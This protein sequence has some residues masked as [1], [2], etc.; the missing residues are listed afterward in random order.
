MKKRSLIFVLITLCLALL[1]VAAFAAD[2]QLTRAELAEMVYN[3]FLP[4]ASGVLPEFSDIAGC[5]SEQQQAIRVMAANGVISGSKEGV[6]DPYGVANRGMAA[7]II[8][9]MYGNAPADA[10]TI[11]ND[12]AGTPFAPAIDYLA[13][14]GILLATDAIDGGF[15]PFEPASVVDVSTW[16]SR[17]NTGNE[18]NG[19]ND[20]EVGVADDENAGNNETPEDENI[21]DEKI[22]DGNAADADDTNTDAPVT[23]SRVYIASDWAQW[24]V[25]YADKLGLMPESFYDKDL[26]QN[27]TRAEFAAVAVKVYEA[28]AGTPALPAVVHPFTDTNDIEVLKAYNVGITNG[29]GDGT[30]YEPDSILN[31]EQL[32]TM[33][34]RVFKRVTIPGWTLATDAQFELPYEM[35]ALFADDADISGWARDS[36]YFMAANNIVGGVGENRYAPKNTTT[37]EE[38]I[39]YANATREQA[40]LIA[41]RMVENLGK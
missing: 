13:A 18:N 10:Q 5:T 33:L 27:I 25:A 7:I 19:D 26:T 1:P 28:L 12:A 6:F 4:E 17:I 11:F 14:N 41:V 24:E 30:V 20:T 21:D 32:A 15:K 3:K 8:W 37:E 40:L 36:V 39:G 29:T 38:A 16:L 9:R 35:P 2:G 22:N 23:E 34:T 31:R